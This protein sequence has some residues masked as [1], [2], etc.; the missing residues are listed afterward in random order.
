MR[1]DVDSNANFFKLIIAGNR[2]RAF[3]SVKLTSKTTHVSISAPNPSHVI[4]HHTI[5]DETM[6]ADSKQS[7]ITIKVRHLLLGDFH[8][9]LY[10][11][12]RYDGSASMYVC[13]CV[14]AWVRV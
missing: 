9:K 14:Y 12:S 7:D 6:Q 3:P 5:R 1:N 8:F 13:E 11:C 10:L 4:T 2:I